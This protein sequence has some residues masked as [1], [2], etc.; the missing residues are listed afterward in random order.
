LELR[1]PLQAPKP[2]GFQGAGG[3]CLPAAYQTIDIRIEK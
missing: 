2:W 1:L 3:L